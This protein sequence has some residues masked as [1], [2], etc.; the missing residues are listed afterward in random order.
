MTVEIERSGSDELF[1]LLQKILP[2]HLLSRGMHAL[3]RSRQP[4]VR[5]LIL[6]VVLRS[7]PQIDMREALQPDPFTYESFNAFFTRELR[8]GTRPIATEAHVLVSPVD[9]TVS[10]LGRTDAGA[11]LQAKGM[12]Y[13]CEG[14]LADAP[15]AARYHGG[16]FACLYL[17]PYNYHRIHMPC[18]A[19]LRATRYVPGQ[20]FSVNAATARTVPDLFARNERVVCDFDT[21]DGPLCLVL[22]G[23]LFVASIET[24]FAGEINPPP[25]RGGKVRVIESGVGRRFRRGEELGRFNMGSTV[26]VL[27][28]AAA[29]FAPR[30]EAGEPVRLGQVLARVGA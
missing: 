17:A 28:G 6:R 5:N 24:V 11:L 22:V 25:S 26:I 29:A 21:D 4:V 2:Q 10:Q 14:L 23:A 7:Y 20:L 18:D 8:P 9:G 15:A 1:T 16:S 12:R 13:T 19:V 27:T 3:A 30:V